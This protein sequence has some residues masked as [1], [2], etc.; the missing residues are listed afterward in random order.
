MVDRGVFEGFS[1][2]GSPIKKTYDGNLESL[3]KTV[4]SPPAK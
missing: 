2:G 3:L 4:S 1:R